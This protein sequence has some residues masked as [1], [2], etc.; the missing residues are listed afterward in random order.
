VGCS[1]GVVSISNRSF[2]VQSN[3]VHNAIN[4]DSLIWLGSLVSSTDAEDRSR[5]ARSASN[6]RS[7]APVHTSRRAAAIRSFHPIF[8]QTDPPR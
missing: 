8:M 2:G 7:W 5:P 6:R 4:V 3:A 1:T